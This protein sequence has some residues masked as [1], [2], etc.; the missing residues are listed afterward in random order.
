MTKTFP[1]LIEDMG[2]GRGYEAAIH[3]ALQSRSLGE[4][5]I[6]VRLSHR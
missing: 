2:E 3:Y 4:I 6:Q 1:D 5:P